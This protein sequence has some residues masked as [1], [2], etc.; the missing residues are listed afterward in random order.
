[1]LILIAA[2]L[3]IRQNK[4]H[5]G[6][7]LKRV[8]HDKLFGLSSKKVWKINSKLYLC[9]YGINDVRTISPNSTSE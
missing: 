3:Q 7:M 4:F 6:Q 5:R 9:I 2:E 1:M 8:Q